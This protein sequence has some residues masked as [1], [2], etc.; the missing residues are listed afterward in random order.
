M[1]P[2]VQPSCGLFVEFS[3]ASDFEEI[4]LH[5]CDCSKLINSL[6]FV[7]GLISEEK[8]HKYQYQNDQLIFTIYLFCVRLP[9]TQETEELQ[10]NQSC[11]A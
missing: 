10:L 6:K 9:G 11:K 2:E 7:H 1:S 3:R 5:Y 4:K 8:N